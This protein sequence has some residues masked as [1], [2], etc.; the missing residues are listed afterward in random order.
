LTE[1]DFYYLNREAPEGSLQEPHNPN[2]PVSNYQ[3]PSGDIKGKKNGKQIS[4][5][6]NRVDNVLNQKQ[7]EQR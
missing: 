4:G 3:D 6:M 2:G 1:S 7:K 5:S